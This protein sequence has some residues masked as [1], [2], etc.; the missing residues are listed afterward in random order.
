MDIAL[1]NVRITFQKNVTVTD[2]IGNHKNT[3]EDVFDC[4]ATVSGESGQE[5]QEAGQTLENE[6]CA[7]T[8]RYCRETA[9]IRETTHRIMFQ[10]EIYDIERIDHMNYKK[11]VLKFWCRKARR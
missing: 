3:W 8:V 4:Y 9:G 10:G 6:A 7:F 2:V 1:L 5:K 11:K